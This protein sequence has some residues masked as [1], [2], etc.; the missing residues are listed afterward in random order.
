MAE[1]RGRSEKTIEARLVVRDPFNKHKWE[2]GGFK[3][4]EGKGAGEK[5]EPW[6]KFDKNRAD[7]ELEK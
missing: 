1:Q 3:G 7:W 2:G 5:M 4:E 6:K